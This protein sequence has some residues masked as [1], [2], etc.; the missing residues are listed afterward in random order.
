MKK[1]VNNPCDED[2]LQKDDNIIDEL[3]TYCFQRAFIGLLIS[4]YA[5]Y[6]Q[7]GLP[8][9]PKDVTQAKA[10]WIETKNGCI[11]TFQ[12]GYEITNNKKDFV[13]SKDIKDYI[14][15]SNI[16]VIMKKFGNEIKK[17]C[18]KNNYTNVINKGKKINGK[19]IQ[20]W[21]VIKVY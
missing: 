17:Y 19:N 16:G 4:E 1:F 3:K 7:N 10:N 12:E 15:E 6:Q 11:E 21:F 9:E 20:G 13:V 18:K 5:Q 14:K 8:P 2:E